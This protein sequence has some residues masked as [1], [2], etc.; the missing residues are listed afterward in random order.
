M[1]WSKVQLFGR[2]FVSATSI[3]EVAEHIVDERENATSNDF[4][5]TPNAYVIVT[6]SEPRYH[7]ISDFYSNAG[8]ILPDGMPI[9]WLSKLRGKP[10]ESRLAGSDLFP[11]LWGRLKQRQIP[12]TLILP[13]A[14]M[15]AMFHKDN[16][17]C[18]CLVPKFFDPSDEDYIAQFVSGACD[19]VVSS[20]SEYVFLGLS[21]PKQEV[22]AIEMDK[23]LRKRSYHKGVL[24]LLLG[25]SYEFYFGLKKRAPAFYRNTGLEWLYRFMQEPGRMWKRYTVGNLR[26]MVLAIKELFKK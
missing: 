5:V 25:A 9:V 12:C 23:E 10:L 4:L 15:A 2:G 3:A 7:Y 26:F 13:S 21:F 11:E 14:K 24:F 16:T 18:S 20:G 22:L 19:A 8:Y 1:S 6:Y 17:H